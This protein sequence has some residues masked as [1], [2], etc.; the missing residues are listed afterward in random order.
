MSKSNSAQKEK[1]LSLW[2]DWMM[3]RGTATNCAIN[4]IKHT[5]SIH[6]HV[7]GE[8]MNCQEF[9]HMRSVIVS[10]L[11]DDQINSQLDF[12]QSLIDIDGVTNA[13]IESSMQRLAEYDDYLKSEYYYYLK[14]EYD[15][16]LKSV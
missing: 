5:Q 10:V 6:D 4:L 1:E 14:S 12:D 9:V 7:I 13:M 11:S 16:Y 3:A 15:K 2:L 8:Y